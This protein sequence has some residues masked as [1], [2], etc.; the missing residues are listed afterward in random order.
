MGLKAHGPDTAALNLGIQFSQQI[1]ALL[2]SRSTQAFFSQEEIDP[3]VFLFH[4]GFI[5]DSEATNTR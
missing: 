4:H 3:Q 2:R 1:R 5:D